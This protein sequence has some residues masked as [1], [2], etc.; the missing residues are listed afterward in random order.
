MK[1]E[2]SQSPNSY[3]LLELAKNEKIIIEKGCLIYSDGEYDFENKIE[4]E[5]YKNIV[6]KIFGGKSLTYNIYTAK[7]EL[8]MGFSA[9][10]T[11]EIFSLEI[12]KQHP[13]LFYG[14]QHFARTTDIQ[15]KSG[16]MSQDFLVK[17]EGSGILFL[18]VYG[19]LI[20]K[21]IDSKK[22]I[23]VDEDALIAFEEGIEY[24]W[25]TG[26]VKKLITS[27]EGGLFKLSGKGKIWIQSK[28]KIEYKKD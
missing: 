4:L 22:P 28:D 2:I 20:E 24:E 21:L 8:K 14:S 6:S 10:D 18:K 5:S 1:F 16:G 7:E 3:L 13:I 26:G 15:I 27:G 19:T 17:T 9:K 12:N 11:A 23:Y 25:I